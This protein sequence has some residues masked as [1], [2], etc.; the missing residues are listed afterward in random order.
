MDKNTQIEA[1]RFSR[2]PKHHEQELL[3]LIEKD[4]PDFQGRLLDIGCAAGAFIDL[5]NA[6]NSKAQYVGFDL[7]AE[8]IDIAKTRF[9]K[10]INCN[11]FISDVLSYLPERKYDVIV[12]SGVL[13]IFEEYEDLLTKWLS[14]L[15]E[16]GSLYIFGRFNSRDI[17]TIIRFRN[18]MNG[19]EWEG[20]LTSYS[21][22]TVS[23]FLTEKGYK[24]EFIRFN[25]PIKLQESPN[26]IRTYTKKTDDGEVLVVNGANILTEHYFLIVQ[27]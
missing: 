8:L 15:E 20:G 12:A 14:W 17:D 23:K 2:E 13:S 1:Y 3:K 18:N 21:I 25:L 11:F 9:S 16:S 24:F 5:M 19:G 4:N 22:H 10:T 6:K 26:P 7:S 27:K